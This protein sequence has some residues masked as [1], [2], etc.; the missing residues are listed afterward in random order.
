MIR[1]ILGSKKQ[2][3]QKIWFIHIPK[4]A[5]TS[6]VKA[7]NIRP[8]SHI[9]AKEILESSDKQRYLN[10]YSFCVVRHPYNRFI[11]LYNYAKMEKS[12]YHD[13]IEPKNSIYGEHLDYKTLKNASIE[14]CAELLLKGKLKHDLVWNHWRPQSSWVYDETFKNLLV[15]RVFHLEK[16]EELYDSNII[17][18]KKKVPQL[19]TSSTSINIGDLDN[20]TKEILV[21]YYKKDFELFNYKT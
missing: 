12:Y 5:G 18:L 13:N 20:N 1:R 7:L 8:V 19:N 2:K 4:N 15:D 6:I 17:N 9:T 10:S 14:E 11:S 16:I 21:N 3:K